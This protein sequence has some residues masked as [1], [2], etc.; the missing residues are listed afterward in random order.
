MSAGYPLCK[1]RNTGVQVMM[2]CSPSAPASALLSG[3]EPELT[4]KLTSPASYSSI[5]RLYTGRGLEP[6]GRPSTKLGCPGRGVNELI[7]LTMYSAICAASA[8]A[9]SRSIWRDV[10]SCRPGPWYL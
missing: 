10:H 7:L 1:L 6:V 9:P 5:S 3:P 8:A 2:S 4:L